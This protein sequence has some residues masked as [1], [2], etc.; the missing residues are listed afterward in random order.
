MTEPGRKRNNY[1]CGH[2]ADVENITLIRGLIA[3]SDSEFADELLAWFDDRM[4]VAMS[5]LWG[6]VP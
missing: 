4:E 1:G 2:S 3:D 6:V 5:E